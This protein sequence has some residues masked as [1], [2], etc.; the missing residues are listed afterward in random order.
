MCVRFFVRTSIINQN[1]SRLQPNK[2]EKFSCIT[3]IIFV[4]IEIVT[5]FYGGFSDAKL[6][7]RKVS[8]PEN[9]KS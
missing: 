9:S 1:M 2:L 6:Y 7:Y 8:T 3:M 5:C 4:M